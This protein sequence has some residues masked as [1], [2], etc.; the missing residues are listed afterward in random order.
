[1]FASISAQIS[2]VDSQKNNK[3]YF[4]QV[5][6]FKAKMHKIW[7][8]LGLFLRPS[9]GSLQRSPNVLT[10]FQRSYFYRTG[11]KERKK[12][13]KKYS[14]STKGNGKQKKKGR[15]RKRKRGKLPQGHWSFPLW[16]LHTTTLQEVW[17]P[18]SVTLPHRWLQA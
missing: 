8:R 12:E 13:R 11:R 18:R 1:M 3:H 16:A 7:S 14:K 4:D 17:N 15:E 5:S 10:E 9:C 2:L 6:H